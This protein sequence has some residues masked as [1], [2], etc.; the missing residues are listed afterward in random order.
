[1]SKFRS[2][3]EAGYIFDDSFPGLEECFKKEKKM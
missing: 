3:N 2:R 1:M